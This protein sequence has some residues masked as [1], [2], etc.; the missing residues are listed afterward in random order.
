LYL[1]AGERDEAR[2]ELVRAKEM[3]EEIGYRRRDGEVREL[4]AETR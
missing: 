1:A 4:E 2:A 3:V